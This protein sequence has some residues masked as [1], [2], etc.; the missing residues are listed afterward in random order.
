MINV[1][2]TKTS[3]W[4]YD[5]LVN[6][7]FN[8]TLYNT[9]VKFTLFDKNTKIVQN[10]YKNII[11]FNN[12]NSLKQVENMIHVLK[13]KVVFHLSDEY[14]QD[15]KY[16][17]LYC[18]YNILVFH[19]YNH[20]NI[21]YNYDI[22]FQIPLA[23]VS[24]YCD[25]KSSL[26]IELSSDK[27]YDFSYVGML[28]KD[29]KEM[30]DTFAK[31]F[32]KNYVHTGKTNWSNPQNQ[33]IKP[34]EVYDIYHKSIFVP[35]GRGNKSL[36]CSR[37]Y[38]SILAGAIP[39]MCCS[40]EELKDSYKFNGNLPQIIS[41]ETWDEAIILCKD[42]YHDEMKKND[43]IQYNLKWWKEQIMDISFKINN[44]FI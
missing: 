23:Y 21:T 15:H 37:L 8:K 14:G 11:V 34:L 12:K 18:K 2:Y 40:Q 20:N 25:D 6:D 22:Q 43:I 35:I 28:K 44:Q 4:E 29:R 42:I 1:Y 10:D 7:I 27:Q 19:Q 33:E 26:D 13:P 17:D 24:C 30:L 39:V 9:E 5:F 32:T 36:D 41:A 38:E 16:Y 3:M 31:E